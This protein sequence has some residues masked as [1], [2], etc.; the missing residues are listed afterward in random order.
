V[1]LTKVD[2]RVDPLCSTFEAPGGGDGGPEPRPARAAAAKR[3][4]ASGL[5]FRVPKR[6]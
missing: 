2:A 3:T 4:P 1:T 6:R 5:R